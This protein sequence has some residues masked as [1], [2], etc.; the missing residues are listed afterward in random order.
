M[1]TQ[2]RFVSFLLAFVMIFSIISSAGI[3]AFAASSP[4]FKFEVGNFSVGQE[5]EIKV[6]LADIQGL[7]YAVFD[8]FYD[9][10]YLEFISITRAADATY[11][12]GVGGLNIET[13]NCISFAII[14]DFWAEY[15]TSL[16]VIKMKALKAGKTSISAKT[17][18]IEG[19]EPLKAV[20]QIGHNYSKK[21]IAPTCTQKG[22]TLYTC[23]D[24][25]NSYKSD[26]KNAKGHKYS[27]ACDTSCNT[28]G[29][30]RKTTHTYKTV[31]T[32]ATLTKNG[33]TKTYCTVCGQVKT[34]T[35]VY[36]PK[37]ISLSATKF[38]YNGSVKGPGVTV[39]NS[40]GKALIKGTDYTVKYADGR[41]NVGQYKVTITFKGNYSG[42][43]TLTFYILPGKTSKITP[44]AT[45]TT[46][47]ATWN[48]VT[49]ATG[50]KV[51]LL[52]ANGKVVKK[53]TTTK[54]TYTF[55]KLSAGTTYKVRVTAYTTISGKNQYSVGS[56]NLT[57]ATKP[58]TPTLTL[59]SSVKG[60][61]NIK[62][63]N[64][65]GETGYQVYYAT[66]K[67]GTYSKA[68]VYTANT[69]SGSKSKLT[70]GKTYYFKV[71]AYKKVGSTTVYGAWSSVKS[72]K[73]K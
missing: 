26:Y 44:T 39:K 62:W 30:T 64:V 36:Y 59:S 31:K 50:Y 57:T 20:I 10:E 5:V 67:N 68:G 70:S 33:S 53:I 40:Q 48:K 58:A 46:L 43:K 22:Y 66:S 21:V 25:K 15:D 51:E 69:V 12:M 72:V 7:E 24:C 9:P 49:G 60:K 8:F 19:C 14:Y 27:N 2:K 28:C 71:R 1:S 37:T 55:S 42:T 29:A 61:A 32:K 38:T 35:T 63:S 17:A 41:K 3:S 65:A 23:S 11:D 18:E 52:N 16:C 56:T 54:L 34:N 47:K 4:S 73:I 45:T 6:S 13:P